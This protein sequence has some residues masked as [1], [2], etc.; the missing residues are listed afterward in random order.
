M[1]NRTETKK[2]GGGTGKHALKGRRE[3]KQMERRMKVGVE[4]SVKI[5]RKTIIRRK[6]DKRRR[7]KLDTGFEIGGRGHVRRKG[8]QQNKRETH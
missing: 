2:K 5:V 4:R 1:K 8:E 6:G 7:R 3:E